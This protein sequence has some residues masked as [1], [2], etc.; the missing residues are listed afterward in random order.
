MRYVFL[1]KGYIAKECLR[2]ALGNDL[3]QFCPSAIVADQDCLSLF[4]KNTDIITCLC[5][6]SRNEKYVIDAITDANPDF[7]LSVQYPWIISSDVLDLVS[8][9]A[10]NI[11]NAKLP[12]YRGHGALSYEI[13]NQDEIHVSTLHLMAQE[14]DRGYYVKTEETLID[15]DD[16][17]Y[18]L[19]QKSIDCC[20][21]L[22]RWLVIEGNW[23]LENCL[24]KKIVGQGNYYSKKGL[25]ETKLVPENACVETIRRYARAFHFPPHEPA[26]I[27][28]GSK[29][30]HLVLDS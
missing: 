28:S 8:G 14:V 17:A 20:T 16:T 19:W 3:Q 29:K 7:I 30:I 26:Y 25:N 21:R 22:F 15:I 10:F 1:G 4:E 12:E 2:I 9:K 13:L 18:S 23:N 11:H 27:I 6:D 24:I 5:G